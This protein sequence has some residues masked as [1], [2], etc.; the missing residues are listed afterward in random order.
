M[1]FTDP[2]LQHQHRQP[3]GTAES[4][5]TRGAG[6]ALIWS[7]FLEKRPGFTVQRED[8]ARIIDHE[9]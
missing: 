3:G 6:K 1:V 8:D 4:S 7:K 5:S 9:V 2:S